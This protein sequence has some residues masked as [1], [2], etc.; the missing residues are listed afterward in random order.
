MMNWEK[1][2]S[3]KRTGQNNR[4]Y[5]ERSPFQKD[6]D[7]IIFSSAFRRLQDKTQVFPLAA[8]DYV[9]TRLTHSLEVSSVGRSIANQVGDRIINK[10]NLK[11]ISYDDFG[12][13]VAASCL[14]HDIGNPAFG[15]FGEVAIREFFTHT[16][17]GKEICNKVSK[18]QAAD[19]CNF[20]G[21]AQG[22]RILNSLQNPD[23][24][25]GL[26]L[27]YA[28]IGAFTKYPCTSSDI[29][30]KK[31]S[32][33]KNGLLLN[34]IQTFSI[35]ADELGLIK[36]KNSW[37]RHPLVFLMEAADDICYAIIDIEDAHQIK[38]IDYISAFDLLSPLAK[39]Y[40]KSNFNKIESNSDKI[41]YLRAK[42]IGCLVEETISCFLDL[43]EKILNDEQNLAIADCIE[44]KENL[45]KLTDFAAKNIY[46]CT[47]VVET[48]MAGHRILG[49][50]MQL[51][52]TAIED[53]ADN[54]KLAKS[55][56]H[57]LVN[58]LPS[59]FIS[60]NRVPDK[61]TYIRVLKI[62]DFI[63]GMTDSYA[64]SLYQK[65]TGIVL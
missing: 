56:S 40:D 22:F 64:V 62:I 49:E 29:N 4:E 12:S 14:A 45:K 54:G 60:S 20:E 41:S 28:T 47:T 55:S 34:D 46:T 18:E 26:Q 44:S 16:S 25:G 23:N 65:L 57:M 61:S 58:L 8:N 3:N 5:N 48:E 21:N 50:L 32:T 10:Y 17:I 53:I 36:N 31:I 9:R 39:N 59:R 15:H 19:L 43:E 6:V 27:T 35:I 7:R 1:L 42:A 2:L 33:K 37:A 52:C 63:S 13:I 51:F 24:D 30:T 38:K 11:N